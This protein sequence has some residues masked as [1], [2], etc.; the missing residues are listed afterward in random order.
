[1]TPR[2]AILGAGAGG[3]AMAVALRDAGMSDVTILEKS[4]GFGGT[5]RDNTYPGCACDAPSH[6]YSFSFAP[7][8]DWSRK[9]AD[10]PEILDY[11]ERV[12]LD[13]RLDRSTRFGSEVASLEWDDDRA[14][15][16]VRTVAG[17]RLEFDVVVAALG[18]LN[19]PG[20][21]D[22]PGL[23]TFTGTAFHSARWNHDHDLV[24][25]RVAVIGNGASAV[26]F[27]PEVAAE[28]A[29]VTIFQRSANWIM[30]KPDRE[31]RRSERW[32]FRHV[33]GLRRAYRAS[34]YARFESRFM[35]FRRGSRLGRS[36][37]RVMRRQLEPIVRD[38]ITEE[39][40]VPDYPPGCKR[41]LISNDYL[42]TLHRPDVSVTTAPIV[43]VD[44]TAV[45][46]ADGGRHEVDTIIF[47]TGFESTSFLAPV[48][49]TGRAGRSLSEVWEKGAT[50]YLGMAMPEFPNLFLL[51]GPNTNL[52]H[53][54]IIFMLEC[55][56]RFTAS[57]L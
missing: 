33:P 13:H 14:T 29:H 18:Q 47:G 9:F 39:M 55:Q 35:L 57:I 49:V 4:D 34:I 44:A 52:G 5:W 53:N 43:A 28:A 1:M 3:I 32:A 40:V 25:R 24:G 56:A 12:A 41:I 51:Y 45:L 15:W 50:A 38:E 17:E 6:L 27:V 22:I 31:F 54:S 2:I 19:R 20:L 46:T 36:V 11:M 8:P 30:P 37:A 10:Q 26:Q 7:N 48:E 42:D 21:P 16:E 23:E